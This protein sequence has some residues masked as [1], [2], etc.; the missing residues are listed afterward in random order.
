MFGVNLDTGTGNNLY[1]FSGL[2][3]SGLK[4]NL[5]QNSTTSLIAGIPNPGNGMFDPISPNLM[6]KIYDSKALTPQIINNYLNKV[7]ETYNKTESFSES[8]P[9][10]EKYR[11]IVDE[12]LEKY[13]TPEESEDMKNTSGEETVSETFEQGDVP[14]NDDSEFSHYGI[15]GEI[16]DKYG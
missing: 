4:N 12:I 3:V 16:F 10:R 7:D 14:G 13:N 5:F 6:Y 2:D 11:T 8:V 15:V 9:E 1:G